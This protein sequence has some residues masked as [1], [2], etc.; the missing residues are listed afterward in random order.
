MKIKEFK[1]KSGDKDYRKIEFSA[2]D[3]LDDIIE[4]FDKDKR[5]AYGVLNWEV[6]GQVRSISTAARQLSLSQL[7]ELLQEMF[8]KSAES[9]ETYK[10]AKIRFL[11]GSITQ[12]KFA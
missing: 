4:V 3:G 8:E 7:D 11:G 1:S 12:F 10:T 2:E 6:E 5:F 9:L